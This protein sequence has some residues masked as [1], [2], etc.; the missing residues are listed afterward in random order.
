MWGNVGP[1]P[2][3]QGVSLDDIGTYDSA[4]GVGGV[5]G[6]LCFNWFEGKVDRIIDGDTV[7][8]IV[9]L[10]F[11]V[12]IKVRCRLSQINAPETYGV[13][14]VA[15]LAARDYLMNLLPEG[16]EILIEVKNKKSFD[17][18]VANLYVFGQNVGDLLIEAFHAEAL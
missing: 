9:C 4:R 11:N 13:E 2:G 17:R 10:G 12:T 18:H 16:K 6:D 14:K 3:P 1:G 7:D 5:P 8:V 15:G